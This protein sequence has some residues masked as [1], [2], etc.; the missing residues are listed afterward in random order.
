MHLSSAW[1]GWQL[2]ACYLVNSHIRFDWIWSCPDTRGRFSSGTCSLRNTII[3]FV[4][5]NQMALVKR[6]ATRIECPGA[7]G[8]LTTDLANNKNEKAQLSSQ[9]LKLL[10]KET[11]SLLA[12][13][14]R[15]RAFQPA[16]ANAEKEEPHLLL[17][18]LGTTASNASAERKVL[19]R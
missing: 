10:L 3:F 7:T 1:H 15:G 8:Y 9:V 2:S 4:L 5:S 6:A 18:I 14:C 13:R 16:A 12:Y 19:E 11:T 17:F